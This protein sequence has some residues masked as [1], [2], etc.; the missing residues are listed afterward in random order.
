M[1]ILIRSKKYGNK[2]CYFDKNDLPI[3]SKHT[4]HLRKHNHSDILYA[5]TN[6]YCKVTK[7]C[8]TK[9]MHR[10]I[11]K[12]PQKHIDHKDGNGLNN[13]RNNLRRCNRSQNL[14]NRKVLQKNNTVGFKGVYYE[15]SSNKY[16]VMIGV[17]RVRLSGGR[18]KNPIDAAKMYN[19][20][21]LKHHG[22]FARLN[23]I[24]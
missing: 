17:K 14:S 7:T 11:L 23:T 15:S 8:S 10:M 3:I 21:A 4:W 20:L 6:I 24:Q 13:R 16:R 5:G 18:F 9:N 12:S 19:Q 2:W 22:E 1:K